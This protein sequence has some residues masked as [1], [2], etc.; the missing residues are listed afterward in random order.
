MREKIRPLIKSNIYKIV[1][2]ST[3]LAAI[4]TFIIKEDKPILLF[5]LI[6]PFFLA[7][8]WFFSQDKQIKEFKE[9]FNKKFP[10]LEKTLVVIFRVFVFFVF[11]FSI[12]IVA[13]GII[14]TFERM[15]VERIKA[16][17]ERVK[18][19]KQKIYALGEETYQKCLDKV[20]NLDTWIMEKS[21]YIPLRAQEPFYIPKK[22]NKY[23]DEWI[24]AGRPN[25]NQRKGYW[26][27]A[28]MI[29]MIE[30]HSSFCDEF[31][32][33]LIKYFLDTKSKEVSI[34]Y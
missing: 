23:F 25:Y 12:F 14:D 22:V 27:V 26:E 9:T 4:F 33:N 13:I 28:F 24:D 31:D 6:A 15:K 3:I 8:V 29:W 34:S 18:A 10:F 30:N 7:I 17:Q 20:A 2:I 32:I 1:V 16:E 21:S 19:E 5:F 11:L